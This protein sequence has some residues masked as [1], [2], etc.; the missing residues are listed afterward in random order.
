MQG[1]Q[2]SLSS[3]RGKVV[4]LNFWSKSCGP[5]LQEMPEFAEFTQVLAPMS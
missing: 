3:Y 4:V 2:V 5:C 1:R